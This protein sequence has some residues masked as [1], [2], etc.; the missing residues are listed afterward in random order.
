QTRKI[1][2][3]LINS[4]TGLLPKW[5]EHLSKTEFAGRNLHR[6][7]ATRWNSTHNMLECFLELKG[8][9]SEFVD[10]ASYGISEYSLTE[11]EWEIIGGLVTT[12]QILYDATLYFSANGTSI[13][14]VIPAM[15]IIDEAF[16]SGMLDNET[17]SEPIRHALT[18]GKRTLNKYYSLT[19]DSALYRIAMGMFFFFHS[20]LCS[21]SFYS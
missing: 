2:F 18:I 9:I 7:V 14:A 1:A 16:A 11:E 19:D 20:C 17:L 6:D 10:H 3:K 13:A 12:L 4:T 8:P 5:R 15:D 21:Y